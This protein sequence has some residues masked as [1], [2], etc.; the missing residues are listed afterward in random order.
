M[1]TKTVTLPTYSENYI[2][3]LKQGLFLSIELNVALL[4]L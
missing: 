4:L 3:F 1:E 2:D